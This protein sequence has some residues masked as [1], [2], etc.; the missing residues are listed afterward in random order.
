MLNEDV[1]TSQGP[2]WSAGT[3]WGLGFRG[4][5]SLVPKV[6]TAIRDNYRQQIFRLN[7]SLAKV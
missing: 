5:S 2:G 6:L 7:E 4:L 3:C 1:S